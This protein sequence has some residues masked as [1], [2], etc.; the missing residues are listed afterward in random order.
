M[1]LVLG[2]PGTFPSALSGP[3]LC[4]PRKL[5]GRVPWRPRRGACVEPSQSSRLRASVCPEG[6]PTRCTRAVASSQSWS[7]IKCCCFSHLVGPCC[8]TTEMEQRAS[9]CPN[10]PC[11]A[12]TSG[13]LFR[14]VRPHGRQSTGLPSSAEGTLSAQTGVAWLYTSPTLTPRQRQGST[15]RGERGG[16]RTA[17]SDARWSPA[18]WRPVTRS[19]TTCA[20]PTSHPHTLG[21]SQHRCPG[22]SCVSVGV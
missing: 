3:G 2:R 13:L 9:E 16:Q 5:E 17:A 21:S 1:T 6:N 15:L 19:V 12:L 8:A 4:P 10:G 22:P 7:G 20:G 18:W 14:M 11:G